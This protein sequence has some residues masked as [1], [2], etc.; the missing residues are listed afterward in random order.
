ME[1]ANTPAYL[2]T[3]TITAEKS[4]IVQGPGVPTI[5]IVSI[6]KSPLFHFVW[7]TYFAQGT[8]TEEEGSVRSTSSLR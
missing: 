7:S 5:A 2:D 6:F 3:A 1:V 8:L 4:F